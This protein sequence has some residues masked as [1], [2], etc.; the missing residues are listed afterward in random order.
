[1]FSNKIIWSISIF[2][3][4]IKNFRKVLHWYF[5]FKVHLHTSRLTVLLSSASTWMSYRLTFIYSFCSNPSCLTTIFPLAIWGIGTEEWEAVRC[6]SAAMKRMRDSSNSSSYFHEATCEGLIL[7]FFFLFFF[8][9]TALLCV[10]NCRCVWTRRRSSHEPIFLN[11]LLSLAWN[12]RA[13]MFTNMFAACWKTYILLYSCHTGS[14]SQ[15]LSQSGTEAQTFEAV[16][17]PWLTVAVGDD[18]R[19]TTCATMLLIWGRMATWGS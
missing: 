10:Y 18:T 9:N 16:C 4:K 7:Y 15:S 11:L 2:F 17:E 14:G 13:D 1:M 6:S 3:L 12:C 19:S 5:S 8:H